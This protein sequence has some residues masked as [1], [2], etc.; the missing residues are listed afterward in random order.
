MKIRS[1]IKSIYLWTPWSSR[2]PNDYQEVE[3]IQ[4]SWTQYINTWYIPN[5]NSKVEFEYFDKWTMNWVWFG[6]YNNSSSREDRSFWLYQNHVA[7]Q[8]QFYIHYSSNTQVW[9]PASLKTSAK[10]ILD[11][12]TLYIDWTLMYTKSVLSFTSPNTLYFLTWHWSS[13]QDQRMSAKIRYLKIYDNETKVRDMIPCYR[14]SDNVIWMYDLVNNTFYTNSWSWTFTKGDNISRD[15]TNIKAVYIK[16]PAKPRLPSEYTEVEYI[17]SSWSQYI[18]SWV[19]LDTNDKMNWLDMYMKATHTWT[20]N[21]MWAYNWS[22][23]ATM[24][25]ATSANRLRCFIG[26]SSSY[27]DRD[28]LHSD[29]TT[30][31][32]IEY[33]YSS[34]LAT[35]I[36]N[37]TA[38]TQSRSWGYNTWTRPIFIFWRSNSSSYEQLLS[39]KLSKCFIKIWWVLLR[40]FVPCYRKSDNV[41]WL[42]DLVENKFYTNNWSWTFTKGADVW[43]PEL[44]QI[45]PSWS[46]AYEFTYDFR[47]WSFDWFK[48]AWWSNIETNWSYSF[49]SSWLQQTSSSND[50]YISVYVPVDLTNAK[51]ITLVKLWYYVANSWSNG[52]WIWIVTTVSWEYWWNPRIR[53]FINLNTTSPSSYSENWIYYNDSFVSWSKYA[54]TWWDTTQTMIIDLEAKTVV[55]S[56]SWANTKEFTYT[57]SDSQIT[58]IRNMKYALFHQA[59]WYS[60]YN[61]ESIKTAY[62]KVE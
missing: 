62:I 39:M 3:Y 55:Y 43:R 32:E 17:Q 46:K 14:K 18:N 59:R 38:Y 41:I 31:D 54:S 30:Y 51:K 53:W 52:K 20:W 26:N 16:N 6:A 40:D 19:T 9:W 5:W 8:N 45:R 35:F 36:V 7:W 49:T 25:V 27:T 42:Y 24:E 37:W 29:N 58:E 23:F 2:L 12:W 15:L 50:R 57:L 1:D 56:H 21:F 28:V 33:I 47:W 61:S 13:T 48:A 4:S 34:S 11:K 10:I 22:T 44:I 60:S